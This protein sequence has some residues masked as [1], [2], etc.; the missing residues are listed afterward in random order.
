MASHY[1]MMQKIL[2]K[3]KLLIGGIKHIKDEESQKNTEA[4]T[5]TVETAVELLD[6]LKNSA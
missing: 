5:K 3:W 6:F 2:T 4:A 1:E